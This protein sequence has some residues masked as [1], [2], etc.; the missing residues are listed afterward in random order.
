MAADARPTS[1]VSLWTDQVQHMTLSLSPVDG[2]RQVAGRDSRIGFCVI[3]EGSAFGGA[4]HAD[5]DDRA[6]VGD[7]A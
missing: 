4:G 2:F 6:R 7:R 1:M 5:M 3:H